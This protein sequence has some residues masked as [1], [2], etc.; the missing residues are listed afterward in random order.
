MSDEILKKL[1]P[2]AALAGVWEGEAGK[3]VAPDDDRGTERT[4][5]RERM[6]RASS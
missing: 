3:D 4:D 6:P 2:L 5:F 1:G